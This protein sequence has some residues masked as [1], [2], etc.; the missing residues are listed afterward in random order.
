MAS[1]GKADPF[2]RQTPL[3]GVVIGMSVFRAP[4]PAGGPTRPMSGATSIAFGFPLERREPGAAA[5]DTARG[6]GHRP[7]SSSSSTCRI[8]RTSLGRGPPKRASQGFGLLTWCTISRS[9][10]TLWIP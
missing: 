8:A 4:Y 7:G 5:G 3:H 9:L 1:I 10:L 2:G 6:R